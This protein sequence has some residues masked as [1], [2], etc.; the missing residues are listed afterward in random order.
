MVSEQGLD[1]LGMKNVHDA[2]H[3]ACIVLLCTW[4]CDIISYR[5]EEQGTAAG[6]VGSFEIVHAHHNVS[7]SPVHDAL[8]SKFY[9]QK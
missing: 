3:F 4:I 5:M 6:P 1:Q 9:S 8:L 2:S 7:E